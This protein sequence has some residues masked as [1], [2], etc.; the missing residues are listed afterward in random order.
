LAVR[1]DSVE[2]SFTTRVIHN[3]TVFGLDLGSSARPGLWQSVEAATRR[4]NIVMLPALI[5]ATQLIGDFSISSPV[6]TP[7]GDGVNDQVQI[8][9]VAFKVEQSTPQ[10]QIFD[11]AG[12]KLAQLTAS[13]VEGS[14]ST[15][16]WSGREADGNLVLPG[17]YLYLID[18]GAEAGKDTALR[19]IAVAY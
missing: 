5:D 13:T 6:L 4:A 10:I 1:S 12:R 3:A 11:L 8:R 17:I 16:T 19:S 14:T 15:F 9:F 2:I 18:L 7:N